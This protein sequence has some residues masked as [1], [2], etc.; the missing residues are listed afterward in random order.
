MVASGRPRRSLRPRRTYRKKAGARKYTRKPRS[1]LAVARRALK[2]A[3]VATESSSEVKYFTT[4][5]DSTISQ[6]LTVGNYSLAAH[7]QPLVA[8]SGWNEM[9]N[10]GPLRGN[11]AYLKW[12]KG[13]WSIN[14]N[15]EEEAINFTVAV[16]KKKA[17]C[18][19]TDL[20]SFI[21]FRNGVAFYDPRHIKVC[22][23]K[24]FELYPGGS[25]GGDRSGT[26]I[27]QGK[28]FLPVNKMIRFV[29]QGSTGTQTS[30]PQSFQDQYFFLVHT[31]N[32]SVD[33]E[34]PKLSLN[35]MAAWRD[36]DIN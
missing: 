35:L 9:F 1:A 34:N 24:Q 18:D 10:C 32:Q 21:D 11:K 14:M 7:A 25:L 5:T 8:M 27:K 36:T 19:F 15:D 6:P 33:L 20:T 30:E 2:L 31:N 16:I 28:F 3:K 29:T 17:D 26:V 4:Y 13:D 22:Y 12:L 23:Y